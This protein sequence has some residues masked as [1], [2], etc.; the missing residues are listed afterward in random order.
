MDNKLNRIER[1]IESLPNDVET[2][3][4]TLALLP[5]HDD[6]TGGN[7]LT[8]N[9]T[10]CSN[11]DL[12]TCRYSTNS[13]VCINAADKCIGSTNGRGC[14]NACSLVTNKSFC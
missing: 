8:V 11:S 13:D 7:S 5:V 2:P 14:N 10:T 4:A 1:F 12:E 9:S 3:E 6:L